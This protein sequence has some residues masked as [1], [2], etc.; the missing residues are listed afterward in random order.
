MATVTMKD[1]KNVEV[2]LESLMEFVEQNKDN[3]VIHT[4]KRRGDMRNKNV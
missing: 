3:I 1:G 4:V 2:E